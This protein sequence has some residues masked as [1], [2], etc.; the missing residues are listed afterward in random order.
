[1][2]FC[3][4]RLFCASFR[5]H[6]VHF[7]V[8]FFYFLCFFSIIRDIFM[9]SG[10]SMNSL[11]TLNSCGFEWNAR[12]YAGIQKKLEGGLE[13][14]QHCVFMRLLMASCPVSCPVPRRGGSG[15]CCT[16]PRTEMKKNRFPDRFHVALE[17]SRFTIA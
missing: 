13:P 8:H 1:M 4:S 12:K 17:T 5:V 2:N 15:L 16:A 14:P 3:A 9:L 6:R 10:I 7:R 11:K